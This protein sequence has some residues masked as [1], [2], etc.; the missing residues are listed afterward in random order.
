MGVDRPSYV[1]ANKSDDVRK[2]H[3]FMGL[4]RV[5]AAILRDKRGGRLLVPGLA[6]VF[7]TTRSVV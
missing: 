2:G 7:V 1:L 5:V 4:R 3:V 6:R